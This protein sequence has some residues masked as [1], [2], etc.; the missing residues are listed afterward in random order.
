M[1]LIIPPGK[2]DAYLF[3]CDGTIADTMPL[4]YKA[5]SKVL[6]DEGCE[7]SEDEFYGYAGMPVAETVR[8]LNELRG[9]A[10]SPESISGKREALYFE[11]LHLVKPIEEVLEQIRTHH[12]KI[13][14]AVVSGSPRASVLKTLGALDLVDLFPVIVGA[15]DTKKGKPHPDPF[16]LAAQKLGVAP[17]KC[18]VF[19]DGELGIQSAE[20]AGLKWVRV[21]QKRD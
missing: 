21:A 11:H 3:D 14:F 2:F 12:G 20:A 1:K 10:M 4:H 5:W 15:D 8:L 16:L 9:L 6:G 13:P 17:E 19:E 18:L 7:F